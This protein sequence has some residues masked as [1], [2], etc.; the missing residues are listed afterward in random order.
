MIPPNYNLPDG[1]GDEDISPEQEPEESQYVD[2]NE[3]RE[4]FDL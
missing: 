3:P 1:C 2:V 4:D